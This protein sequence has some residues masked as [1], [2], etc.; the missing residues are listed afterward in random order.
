MLLLFKILL[1]P[2]IIAIISIAGRIRGTAVSGLLGGLPVVAGPILVFLSIEHGEVFGS[3]SAQAALAGVIS[4]G[5]FCFLYAAACNRAGIVSSLIVGLLGFGTSTILFS[6]VHLSLARTLILVAV[7]LLAILL[8]F[9]KYAALA[10]GYQIG[11]RDV[12]IRMFAAA[13]VVLLITFCS[14]LLGPNLSGLLAPFPIAGT[15]LAGFTHFHSGADS[16]RRLLHGFIKGLFGMAAFDFILSYYLTSLGISQ[17]V[18][19][20][21]ILALIVS[22]STIALTRRVGTNI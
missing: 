14:D 5:L 13:S 12:L 20:A 7:F 15:I 1:V 18:I 19:L 11:T 10:P 3:A 21:S 2:T 8:T 16:A 4:I 22:G 6:N 17:A 9:P